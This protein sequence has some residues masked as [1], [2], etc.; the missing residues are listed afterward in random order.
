MIWKPKNFLFLQKAYIILMRTAAALSWFSANL[1]NILVLIFIALGPILVTRNVKP[2]DGELFKKGKLR[3]ANGSNC[4]S[5]VQAC[6][7]RNNIFF[8]NY[9]CCIQHSGPAG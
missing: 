8:G 7:S 6:Y 9:Y 5:D 4:F 3:A 1:G 2:S